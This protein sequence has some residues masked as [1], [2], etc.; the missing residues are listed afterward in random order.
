[1]HEIPCPN[2]SRL[3]PVDRASALG[4]LQDFLEFDGSEEAWARYDKVTAKELFCKAG[5]SSNLYD[6]FLEPMLLVLPMCPGEDCSAAAALS[7]F[8]YFALEHQACRPGAPGD[9]DVR[10]LRGSA[11]DLI[12]SPWQHDIEAKGGRVLEGK[13]VS[14]L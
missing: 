8:Q 7:C 12:F 10:W 5:V 9:F 13:F 3:G 6:E 1:M 11:S 2:G 4:L 14:S